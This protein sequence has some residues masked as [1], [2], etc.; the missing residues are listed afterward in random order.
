MVPV[1]SDFPEM[2]SFVEAN[3]CGWKVEP[4]LDA[5]R[6]LIEIIDADMLAAKRV[7]AARA[8]TQYCWENEEPE[9]LRMYES[10]GLRSRTFGT[11]P[12]HG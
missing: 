1:V 11:T 5:L 3:D 10:L 9:L 4:E 6:R 8:G 7:N 12:V 2:G